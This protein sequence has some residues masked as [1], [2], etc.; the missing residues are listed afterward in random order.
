[1]ISRSLDPFQLRT[2]IPYWVCACQRMTSETRC[3]SAALSKQQPT[4]PAQ[5]N[6]QKLHPNFR[7]GRLGMA[8][9]A[10]QRLGLSAKGATLVRTWVL[11]RKRFSVQRGA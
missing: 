1:M 9:R 6:N 10:V 4:K 2:T 7:Q 11:E 5:P 8:F 3:R